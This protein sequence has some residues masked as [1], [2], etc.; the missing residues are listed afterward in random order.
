MVEAVLLWMVVPAAF[1]LAKG[2]SGS[3]FLGLASACLVPLTPLLVPIAANDFRELQ[4]AIPFIVLAVEGMRGRRRWLATAGIAGMLACRQEYAV[5]VASLGLIPPRQPE[6]LGRTARWV[7]ADL[8]RRGRLVADL[9]ALPRVR[10]GLRHRDWIHPPVRG[11]KVPFEAALPAAGEIILL[12]LGAWSAM[13][14]GLPRM[15]LVVFPWAWC[16]A[17][18][19]QTI[20][21]VGTEYWSSVRYMAPLAGVGIAAGLVG[22]CR[23]VRLIDLPGS[24]L[25]AVAGRLGIL[26]VAGLGLFAARAAIESQSAYCAARHLAGRGGR[27]VGL[28][29]AGRARKTA[30]SPIIR[31][32]PR[33]PPERR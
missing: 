25:V 20:G 31:W 15:W 13:L 7:R 28:D 11:A 16:V 10:P 22:L 9:P 33:S 29:R 18:A 27:V 8:L 32:R 21:G 2:E 3:V 4:L 5:L 30:S 24:R 1:V 14:V 23:A 12:G 26:A 19:G 17:R 6:D